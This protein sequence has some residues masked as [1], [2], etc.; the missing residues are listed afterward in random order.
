MS[1][2]WAVVHVE[3]YDAW[4]TIH[5]HEDCSAR[6]ASFFR[7][8]KSD[9]RYQ[10]CNWSLPKEPFDPADLRGSC[11]GR[12]LSFNATLRSPATELL[13]AKSLHGEP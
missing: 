13:L 4:P 2:S 11:R 12:Y 10:G 6:S 1:L 5:N 9:S 3:K 7:I 8:D